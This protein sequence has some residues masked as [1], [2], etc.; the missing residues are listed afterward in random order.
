MDMTIAPEASPMVVA[1][2]AARAEVPGHLVLYR[3]GEFY[4]VLGDDAATVSRL[5]GI[6]LTRSRQ[7]DAP[8]ISMCGIPAGS[9]K[10]AIA[11]LLAAGRKVGVS[12]QPAEAAGERPLRR[13]APG[14]PVGA[15]VLAAGRPNALAV[16]HAEGGTVAGVRSPQVSRAAGSPF[17]RRSCSAPASTRRFP[18]AARRWTRT[19][20]CGT[21]PRWCSG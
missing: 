9:A 4:E 2:A 10:A 8:D 3:V 13:M 6:Q 14:T 7:K 16:A 20:P 21:I 5:L 18:F 17:L 11:R 12:E 15:D 19:A 1:Y